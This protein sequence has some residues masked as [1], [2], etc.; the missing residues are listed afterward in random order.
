MFHII[1]LNIQYGL[2]SFLDL[3]KILPS[4]TRRDM[5]NSTIIHKVRYEARDCVDPKS[6]IFKKI[7]YSLSKLSTHSTNPSVSLIC[8]STSILLLFC[9]V[10]IFWV[11]YNTS[12]LCSY[13]CIY[14]SLWNDRD[15]SQHI[16]NV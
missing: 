1:H 6:R 14:V 12:V 11:A 3:I 7:A 8:I 16:L 15:V 13:T 10:G 2:G 4:R 9:V 5:Q